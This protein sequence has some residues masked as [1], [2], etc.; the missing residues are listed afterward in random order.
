M[1]KEA[2]I[3]I[4][5]VL[6]IVIG[7]IITQKYTLKSVEETSKNL[8]E[9]RENLSTELGNKNEKIDIKEKEEISSKINEKKE[10][11]NNDWKTR[12]KKLAYFIEHDEL[13]KVNTNFI[14]MN[15]FIET[16][17]YADAIGELDKSIFVL[18]H[19]QDK[20]DFNLENIF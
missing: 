13:E 18:K 19:I 12:Y 5:I 15:S 20:Y 16:E 9:L 1:K 8:Q 14:E 11:T 6:A 17:E 2:I 3:C 10:K 7:N 4:V